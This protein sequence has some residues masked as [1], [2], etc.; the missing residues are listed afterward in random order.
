MGMNKI[1]RR[2]FLKLFIPFGI[3]LIFLPKKLFRIKIPRSITHEMLHRK[4]NLA[5]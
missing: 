3:L 1:T 2:K 4:H 5:G